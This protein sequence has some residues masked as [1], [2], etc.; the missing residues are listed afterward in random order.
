MRNLKSSP[1]VIALIAGTFGL[2]GT[3]LGASIEWKKDTSL[4]EFKLKSGIIKKL[5]DGDKNKKETISMALLLLQK[6]LVEDNDNKFKSFLE[7]VDSASSLPIDLNEFSPKSSLRNP[8]EIEITLNKIIYEEGEPIEIGVRTQMD[9]FIRVYYISESKNDIQKVFPND[10]DPNNFTK[11]M[12]F[13]SVSGPGAT[14]TVEAAPPHGFGIVLA[15]A[16]PVSF[17]E[18]TDFLRTYHLKDKGYSILDVAHLGIP[19]NKLKEASFSF[20]V[21]GT[22]K[23]RSLISTPNTFTRPL[24]AAD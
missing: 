18:S 2:L 5:I 19:E 7:D 14:T 17:I 6:G 22:T 1:I 20:R 9:S 13:K 12:Q 23:T 8:N 3:L 16:S 24:T 21:I 10:H 11:S 15:V 4:E